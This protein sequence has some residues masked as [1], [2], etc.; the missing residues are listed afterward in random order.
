MTGLTSNNRSPSGAEA[1]VY[2]KLYYLK[3]YA[4]LN[5]K[6]YCKFRVILLKSTKKQ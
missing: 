6:I 1:S 2:P 5:S 3:K 4:L